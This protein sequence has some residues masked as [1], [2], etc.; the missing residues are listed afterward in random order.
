M[1][2]A[3]CRCRCRP[4]GGR[5]ARRAPAQTAPRAAGSPRARPPGWPSTPGRGV[6][7]RARSA[8]R[9]TTRKRCSWPA[10]LC[11]PHDLTLEVVPSRGRRPA[12]Y[13][14]NVA[15]LWKRRQKHRRSAAEAAAHIRNSGRAYEEPNSGG[16]TERP[17]APPPLAVAHKRGKSPAQISF[18]RDLRLDPD[19]YPNGVELGEAIEKA[20]AERCSSRTGGSFMDVVD[21]WP[22]KSC[23]ACGAD[24]RGETF[25]PE[26]GCPRPECGSLNFA[27]PPETGG[28]QENR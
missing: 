28:A 21:D 9:R 6:A 27:D 23:T 17:A 7:R 12:R 11:R 16:G 20:N 13:A 26:K 10:T 18:A 2:R 24:L 19:A 8:R 15:A 1:T 22:P 3:R 4:D 14:L 5:G 25:D